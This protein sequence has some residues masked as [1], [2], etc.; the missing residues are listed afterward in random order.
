[1]PRPC[2]M[3]LISQIPHV[4]RYRFHICS[5]SVELFGHA[6]PVG[7]DLSQLQPGSYTF[8]VTVTDLSS[9]TSVYRTIPLILTEPS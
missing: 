7:L 2:L 5:D 6:H 4:F 8:R 9:G 3:E 1:M